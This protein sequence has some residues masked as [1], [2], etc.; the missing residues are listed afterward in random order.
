MGD[1]LHD[2]DIYKDARL[3]DWQFKEKEDDL[4]FYLRWM[5]KLNGSVLE[6]ACG[7]GRIVIPASEQGIDV[8]GIDIASDMLKQ[9]RAKAKEFNVSPTLIQGDIRNFKLDKKFSLIYLPF[10]SIA[11]LY[12]IKDVEQCFRCVREH[13]T[14]DGRFIIDYFN[15]DLN[16]FIRDSEEKFPVNSFQD[17]DTGARVTITESN[18]YDRATQINHIK[19]FKTIGCIN[20]EINTLSM[21]IFYPQELAGLF[22]FHGFEIVHKFGKFDETP[23]TSDSQTQIIVSK[24]KQ[25]K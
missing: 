12:T 5:K 8:T 17:D 3:Y 15:P 13:L 20:E 7:T 25:D 1:F 19:W 2:N 10:N 21:R 16:Y 22:E 4:E 9:A 23:F 24:L 18:R 11:H 14:T 6:L